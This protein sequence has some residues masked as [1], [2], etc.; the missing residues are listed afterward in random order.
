M[1]VPKSHIPCEL[2][3]KAEETREVQL[4][5]DDRGFTFAVEWSDEHQKPLAAV[6]GVPPGELL[7]EAWYPNG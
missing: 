2:F 7:E 5:M 1:G 6:V 4:W 3:D